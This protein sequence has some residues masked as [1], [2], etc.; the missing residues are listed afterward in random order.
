MITVYHAD[1]NIFRD[2][3]C[4]GEGD[5]VYTSVTALLNF[6]EGHYTKVATV[7]INDLDV[8]YEL[9]NSIDSPWYESMRVTGA[10]ELFGTAHR[11]SSVGDIFKLGDDLYIVSA[12]GFTK[13]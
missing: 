7:A 10:G 11:S 6:A 4:F 12:M 9:T 1:R 2:S 8:V 3:I 5:A 13:L